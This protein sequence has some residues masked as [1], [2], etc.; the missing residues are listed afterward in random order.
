M[1]HAFSGQVLCVSNTKWDSV[2]HAALVCKYISHNSFSVAKMSV[3][4]MPVFRV[5][6]L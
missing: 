6:C 1:I 2:V 4:N 3:Q 5:C